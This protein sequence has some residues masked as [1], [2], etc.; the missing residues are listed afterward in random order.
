MTVGCFIGTAPEGVPSKKIITKRDFENGLNSLEELAKAYAPYTGFQLT[1]FNPSTDLG[2]LDCDVV[3]WR[4]Y[5]KSARFF[6]K[7]Q[8]S[9]M[10]VKL[11][12]SNITTYQRWFHGHK[13][14]QM[15]VICG[16][17]EGGL[18]CGQIIKLPKRKLRLPQYDKPFIAP[19][20]SSSPNS[21]F[22]RKKTRRFFGGMETVYEERDSNGTLIDTW[23]GISVS[24]SGWSYL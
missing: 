16:D 3:L 14:K 23:A 15:D 6:I 9:M 19:A 20:R 7:D 1:Q 13:D 8:T 4:S 24:S 5:H 11:C 12:L 17:Y 21:F 10:A 18:G 2:G 22:I